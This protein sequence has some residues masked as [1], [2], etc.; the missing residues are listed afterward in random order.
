M[1]DVSRIQEEQEHRYPGLHVRRDG[2]AVVV[3]I[4][5]KFRKRS[6]RQ[7][8]I[9]GEDGRPIDLQPDA[10]PKDSP[11]VNR[12]LVEA[13]AKAH[14][15]QEQ[16][17]PGEYPSVDDLGPVPQ[18]RPQLRQPPAATPASPQPHRS[19]PPRR[20]ARRPESGQATEGPAGAVG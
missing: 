13:I 7:T 8:I 16:L 5:P 17:E 12:K 9:I 14:R 6:G 1:V 20:R 18:S 4:P 11:R 3:H 19:H 2:E 10:R 15:W